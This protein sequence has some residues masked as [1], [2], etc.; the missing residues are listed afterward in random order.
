M[1]HPSKLFLQNIASIYRQISGHKVAK[2]QLLVTKI[3]NTKF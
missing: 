2:I 3:Y 1:K